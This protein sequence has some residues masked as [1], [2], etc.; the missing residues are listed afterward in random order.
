MIFGTSKDLGTCKSTKKNGD[1]CTAFVNVNRCEYCVYHIR[2]EYNK[3]SKRSEL[4]ANFAGRGLAAL[5]NKLLGKSELMYGGKLYTAFPAPRNNKL[6]KRDENR[7]N[8]LSG[9]APTG[10]TKKTKKQKTAA[11]LL[12]SSMNQRKKDLEILRKLGGVK[13]D[14]S[15]SSFTTTFNPSAAVSIEES[16]KNAIDVISKLKAQSNPEPLQQTPKIQD[17]TSVPPKAPVLQKFDGNLVDLGAPISRKQK[18]QAKL[19]ALKYIKQHGPIQ[20]EDPNKVRL[21]R[22]HCE[23]PQAAEKAKK[24]KLDE[25]SFKSDRF[26]KMI[27]LTSAHTDLLEAH[28]NEEQEKYFSKLEKKEQMEE[29]M[30]STYKVPCKAVRCLQCKYTSFSAS[31]LCKTE[32]HRLRV[33][34]AVK[35]F[36][37]CSNCGNR[38]AC[39]ELVPMHPCKNCSS[40][41][42]KKTGMMKEKVVSVK[43]ELSIRGG[44]Q[45]FVNSVVTDANINLLLPVD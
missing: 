27:A 21:K 36:F 44:E 9:A 28:D 33:F 25:S 22:S 38:T 39:L 43:P 32:R 41:K 16:K 26:K 11:V 15:V 24:L 7:L 30:V 2:Q 20:K 12:E 31:E 10:S 29:K 23:T 13:E 6:A 40:S 35:R 18:V 4:Q 45:K 1:K 14:S 5:Q 19:N 17:S 8:M 42:W 37:K 34:D 3:C